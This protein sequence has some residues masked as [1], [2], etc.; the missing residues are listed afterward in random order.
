MRGASSNGGVQS[1]KCSVIIPTRRRAGP[2]RETLDSLAGQ[3]ERDF[4]VIVVVDGEDPETR[5]LAGTY[6]GAYAL[7]WIFQPDQKGQASARN[8]GAAAAKSEVLLFL[9]DD[10]RPVSG[11]LYH[12]LKHHRANSG[13]HEIGV[14]GKIVDQYAVAPRSW[15]ERYL[16][17]TRKPALAH[18]EACLRNQSVAFGKV[19]AF[20]LN[21][22]ILRKTFFAVGGFDPKLDFLDEDTDL[23]ARLYDYGLRFVP[24]P[25]AIVY[26]HDMKDTMAHHYAIA[27]SAGVVDI[28]RRREKKQYNWRLQLLAQMHCSG[29]LRKVAHRLAWHAPWAFQLAGA[30]ARKATDLTGSR[31]SFRLWYRTAAADYWKGI[32]AAGES[33]ESLRELYPSRTPVLMFHSISEPQEVRLRSHSISPEKFRRF[34]ERLKKGGHDSA[35]L[36]EWDKLTTANHRVILTFDDAYDDFMQNA[37]PVLDRLKLKAIV[38]VVVD[39]IGK[40][41][42]WDEV[43]GLP[44]KRLLSA[45]E[46]R[47][48]HRRGIQFGS[49]TLTHPWL[50]NLSDRDLEREVRDSK[51]KLEDLLGVEV[52]CFAY[53]WGNADMR[54]RAAVARAGYKAAVTAEEGLNWSEDPLCLKRVNVAEVDTSPEFV[55]KLRTGKDLRQHLK[56]TLISKGL[57]QD[58]EFRVD[59]KLSAVAMPQFTDP[60]H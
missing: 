60:E 40:T 49:H 53:P 23:G 46:I 11:W 20:G 42:D 34:M 10:T 5:A 6:K 59:K 17:E 52:A 35:D 36:T 16:R 25:E 58:G 14:L 2:L 1:V 12:H 13:P 38:F 9:D 47:E 7:R 57:Y 30:L 45:A 4:E 56:R 50:T 21:T 31:L 29:P 54:V 22:S 41:N 55:L 27:R 26:H 24:E 37:F 39:R 19:A 43:R 44:R 48:L 28:Y 32:R 15:T 8:A 18:F 3:T 33:I 51:R